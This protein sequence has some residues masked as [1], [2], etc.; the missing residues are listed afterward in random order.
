[1]A[2]KT[3]V[4]DKDRVGHWVFSMV[5]GVFDPT[6][7]SAIGLEQNGQLIAGVV[8]DNYN[9]RS[10]C[11]HV[12]AVPGARWVTKEYLRVCFDYPFN[13]LKVC[14]IIGLVDSTN[15]PARRFDEHLGFVQECVITE[16]GRFGD[17]L[18][19]TMTRQQC[20]L[21]GESNGRQTRCPSNTCLRRGRAG[22]CRR[23]PRSSPC[24]HGGQPG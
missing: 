8:F 20:R 2:G 14:K 1:M 9:H 6:T 18:V 11:M 22:H 12:A 3:L 13:Q 19:Y 16:A 24:R 17:L 5:G 4:F 7:S 15:T 23:Q 21:I 10:V